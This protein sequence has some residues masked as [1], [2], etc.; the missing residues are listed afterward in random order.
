MDIM[1]KWPWLIPLRDTI[2]KTLLLMVIHGMGPMM[3]LPMTK[4]TT[5][6]MA[7]IATA[8]VA[9]TLTSGPSILFIWVTL[10]LL[11]KVAMLAT[12]IAFG[13]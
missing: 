11:S 8:L 2:Q 10:E 1:T 5:R 12:V 13:S 4:T 6:T 7:L 3:S 9:T